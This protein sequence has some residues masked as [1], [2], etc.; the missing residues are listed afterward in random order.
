MCIQIG[1]QEK[2]APVNIYY[3]LHTQ[4][5]TDTNWESHACQ[6]AC[7]GRVVQPFREIC[8][9]KLD[10]KIKIKITDVHILFGT[11]MCSLKTFYRPVDVKCSKIPFCA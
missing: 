8:L 9:S 5:E 11:R 4:R 3:I 6:I 1:Q 2:V 7:M 10:L